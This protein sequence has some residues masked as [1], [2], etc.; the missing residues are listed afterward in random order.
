[1][2]E[3][4]RR[5]QN[6]RSK[7]PSDPFAA[8]ND[9]IMSSDD[10][11]D[12]GQKR[13]P[14]DNEN[15]KN[16][17]SQIEEWRKQTTDLQADSRQEMIRD[18]DYYEGYHWTE[19][20][21]RE[22]RS[23]GQEPVVYNQIMPAVDWVLGTERRQRLDWHVLPRSQNGAQVADAKTKLLKYVYDINR[24]GEVQSQAFSDAVK[25]GVGWMETGV[26]SDMTDDPI[27]ID[28][29]DWRN[30]RY[31]AMA[32][33]KDIQDA[34]FIFREKWVDLEVAMVMFPERAGAL[35]AQARMNDTLYDYQGESEYSEDVKSFEEEVGE[36]GGIS[37]VRRSR[38]QLIE[39]WYRVPARV[40]IMRGTAL[41]VLDGDFY[42]Q[43]DET[44]TWLV[45]AGHASLH[46]AVRMQVRC[47]IYSGDVV[48]QDNPSPYR[49]NRFPFVPIWGKR[50]K[51]DNSPFGMIRNLRGPQDDLN[52]QRS[53]ALYILSTQKIIA[54]NDATQDWEEF[55][56][57]ATRP[58]G[59]VRKK[60]ESDVQLHQ[61][62]QLSTSHVQ[63]MDQDSLYIQEA[64]GVTN[65]NLGRDTNANSGRAIIAKQQQGETVTNIFFDNR[66]SAFQTLGE[67]VLSLVEQFYD[68]EKEIRIAGKKG[69]AEWLEINRRQNDGSIKNDILAEKSEFVVATQDYNDTL[70]QAMFETLSEMVSKLDPQVGF[71]LLDMVV[72]LSDM[73]GTEEL[74]SRIRE[75]NGMPDPYADPDDPEEARKIQSRR[76]REAMQ[77]R[78]EMEQQ[79]AEVEQAKAE[80]KKTQ[81]EIQQTYYDS[82]QTRYEA[83]K[84]LAEVDTERAQQEATRA[85]VTFDEIKLRLEKAKTLSDIR[86]AKAEADAKI[87]EHKDQT[88]GR[89]G[90]YREKGLQSNNKGEKTS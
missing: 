62:I 75:L 21:K 5:P 26:R 48:L 34:R 69:I 23:R 54:D 90:P 80:A 82:M 60:P 14:L 72:E 19:N 25:G 79:Q 83:I 3:A 46:E 7:A 89:Q 44:H 76:E 35:K 24:A 86:N 11:P 77:Q 20:E 84:T 63:L 9:P 15:Y 1:M 27:F 36:A 47:M 68:T 10:I 67:I 8:I 50:R 31:D 32:K 12:R 38:V 78:L 6:Y 29:E 52:K 41:G 57:E 81:A 43:N 65:E 55:H 71:Q 70:R 73:P 56:A 37:E 74:V 42:D 30:I 40:Q 22:L 51:R 66:L 59:I 49:H 2:A 18:N 88:E 58:D 64:S 61:N 17:L 45:N 39:C 13:H 4:D 85:G 33:R 16:R 87:E 28:Y 53:K